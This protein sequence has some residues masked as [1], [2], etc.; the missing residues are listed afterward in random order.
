MKKY[1]LFMLCV[2]PLAGNAQG[3]FGRL[4]ERAA[5]TATDLLINKSQ[6][7][8]E[9]KIDKAITPSKNERALIEQPSTKHPKTINDNPANDFKFYTHYD[10][11]PGQMAFYAESFDSANLGELPQGWNS[12][13]NGA[14][15]NLAGIPGNWLKMDQ[16]ASFLSANTAKAGKEFTI[17]FDLVSNFINGS[18]LLP[19][20]QIG[21]LSSGKVAANDNSLL[22]DQRGA[23]MLELEIRPG[24]DEHTFIQL[25]SYNAGREYFA[26][27]ITAYPSLENYNGKVMH[28]AICVQ[29]Q[30]VRMWINGDKAFDVPN[31]IKEDGD[32]NQFFFH[33]DASNYKN[34]DVGFYLGNVKM[35]NGL[36]DTRSKLLNEGAYSTTG[37]LFD[38][39][40]AEVSPQSFGVLNEIAQILKDNT[41]LKLKITGHTDA[42]GKDAANKILSIDRANAVK[43]LLVKQYAI[44]AERLQTDGKGSSQPVAD[45]KTSIGKTQNRRVEFT[46]I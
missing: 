31:A 26:G 33:S 41:T 16:N 7:V 23:K 1:I 42:D 44:E 4:K 11:V 18:Y 21:I 40:K 30:R 29:H 9:R 24:F 39:N 27:P 43:D 35:A 8:A 17:E 6:Q 38:L 46:K 15:V 28:V 22:K 5:Q 20:Y 32:F 25:K 13:G 37:I 12:N 36:P 3:L 34:S 45:N 19:Q 10:Y 2:L 14:V